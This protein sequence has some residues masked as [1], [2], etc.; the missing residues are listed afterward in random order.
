MRIMEVV[1]DL[2]SAR[3]SSLLQRNRE[4]GAIMAPDQVPFFEAQLAWAEYMREVPLHDW[5]WYESVSSNSRKGSELTDS[6]YPIVSDLPGIVCAWTYD[7]MTF[8]PSH[9]IRYNS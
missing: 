4:H 2:C 7:M 8:I 3:S 6:G 5:Q 1:D 9:D